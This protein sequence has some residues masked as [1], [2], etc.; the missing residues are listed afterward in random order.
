MPTRPVPPGVEFV[1]VRHAEKRSD[2]PRDPLLTD[3]G[4]A[5]A[6]RL[7]VSLAAEPLAAVYATSYR[8]TQQTA[9]P[10]AAAHGLPVTTYDAKQE[11]KQLAA[12]LKHRHASGTVLIVGHSNTV[13]GIAAALCDCVVAPIGDSEFDR[14]LHVRIG[15]DGKA[16]LLDT[17]M[18]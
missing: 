1:V 15:G 18:P 10:S 17:R 7:A 5:R 9:A 16:T 8:R 4:L 12:T 3:A 6:Q 11:A 14:R 2:D 13:P